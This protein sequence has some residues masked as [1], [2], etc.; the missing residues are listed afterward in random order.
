MTGPV[1]YYRHPSIH[2]DGVVF[3]SE[4]DVW[5]VP[6]TGGSAR[7][8]T[9]NSGSAMLSRL[10]PDGSTVAFSSR[11]E[12]PLEAH[13]VDSAGG[14]VRRLTWFGGM[15]TVVGWTPDGSSVLVSSDHQQPFPSLMSLW[16]VP[17]DGGPPTALPFGPARSIAY[18]PSGRGVV[19]GRNT[20]DPARWKRYRGGTAG[21]LWVDRHGQGDFVKLIELDGSVAVP[22]WIGSR[23][24]FIS[25]HEG[26]GNIYSCTPTGRNLQRHTDHSD[27]YARYPSTDGV[28]IVYHA[29]ADLWRLDVDATHPERLDVTLSS[30]RPNRSRKFEPAT[31]HLESI[32]LHPLGQS[33]AATARGGVYTMDLWEG[34]PRGLSPGIR[35]SRSPCHVAARRGETRSHIRRQY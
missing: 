24:F 25:D 18:A 13:V 3:V 35:H 31:R 17:L 10:S 16:S 11:D 14:E 21:Q 20:T 12:G 7:R 4:D 28:A 29:G 2:G 30:S 32:D 6:S 8:I 5:A 15:T 22:M 19:I 34:A 33:L 27:F 26:H 23:I 9:S 1:G